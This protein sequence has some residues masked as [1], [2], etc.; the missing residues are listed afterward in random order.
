[1]VT[2]KLP[3]VASG[4]ESSL[5]NEKGSAGAP[6]IGAQAPVDLVVPREVM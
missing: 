4:A 5:A 1:V 6:E 2:S 3:E